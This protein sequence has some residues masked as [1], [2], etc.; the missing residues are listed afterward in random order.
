MVHLQ[1]IP[2]NIKAAVLITELE[3]GCRHECTGIHPEN[4]IGIIGEEKYVIVHLPCAASSAAGAGKADIADDCLELLLRVSPEVGKV[5]P[6]TLDCAGNMSSG[7][8][9]PALR[10]VR[11]LHVGLLKEPRDNLGAELRVERRLNGLEP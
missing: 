3:I 9:S 11:I 5:L 10:R 7:H 4:P 1:R 6:E 2:R 8:R